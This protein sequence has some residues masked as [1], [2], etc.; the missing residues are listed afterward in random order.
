MPLPTTHLLLLRDLE[1]LGGTS[2]LAERDTSALRAVADWIKTFVGRPNKDVGRAGPVCPF[3][4]GAVER[5]T[6]WLAPEQVGN[7]NV[8]EVVQLLDGY[9]RLLLRAQPIQGDATSYKAI[10][11]VFTDLSADRA[12][13]LAE[14]VPMQDLKRVS[15]AEDGVVLGEFH[16]KNDGAAIRNG[17][18]RPFKAPVPFVLIRHAVISDWMFFLDNEDWLRAW[19]RRFGEAAIQA[20]AAQL[21]RT[22]WRTVAS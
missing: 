7:R 4:P 1:D 9:K 22:N 15:Y 10:V 17:S 16:E 11:V 12:S 20:L 5:K 2:P 3:V 13:A 19:A 6:L 21:R 8:A 14:S 18:F